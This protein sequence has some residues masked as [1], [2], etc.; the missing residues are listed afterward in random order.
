M[1]IDV[2]LMQNL[3]LVENA[4]VIGEWRKASTVEEDTSNKNNKIYSIYIFGEVGS[5]TGDQ[6]LAMLKKNQDDK[7]AAAATA[8]AKKDQ[9]KIK[10]TKDT[11]ALVSRHH[12][13]RDLNET[14]AA[15]PSRAAPPKDLRASRLARQ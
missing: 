7:V 12:R 15:R 6:A 9:A 10:K 11:I 3:R 1:D 8:A 4:R 13:L 14:R 2:V 5:A